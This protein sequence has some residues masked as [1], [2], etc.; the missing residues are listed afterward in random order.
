MVECCFVPLGGGLNG[1]RRRNQ[2]V[3]VCSRVVPTAVAK[4][5]KI[6]DFSQMDEHGFKLINLRERKKLNKPGSAFQIGGKYFMRELNGIYS[7]LADEFNVLLG[8]RRRLSISEKLQF[9][10]D[11]EKVK[12]MELAREEETQT[13]SSSSFISRSIYQCTC[14]FLD[15]LFVN[16]PIPRFWL[17]ETVARMPYFAYL[18]V[19]HLYE[20]FGWWHVSELRKIHFA[21][22]WNELHHLLIMEALGGDALWSD[23]FLANHAAIVY[24]WILVITYFLSP[25]TSYKFSE[26]VENHAADTYEQ[27]YKENEELLKTI[28]APDIA[29]QYYERGDLYMFDVFQTESPLGSRRPNCD[30]LYDVFVNIWGDEKEHVKTMEACSDYTNMGELVQSPH[31]RH[32][33]FNDDL[34]YPH[35]IDGE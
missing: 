2:G 19:L 5:P 31:E 7:Q 27:F 16:R 15:V 3:R 25:S 11:D 28:P 26:L 4:M 1:V 18:S 21:E 34:L 14:M 20:T 13:L 35:D 33:G 12:A 23:R 30:N 24:Y 22:D 9:T 10:L 17:L 6:G 8:G 32:Y 29:K